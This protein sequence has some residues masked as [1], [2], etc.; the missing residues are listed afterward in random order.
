MAE[1]NKSG[2]IRTAGIDQ[3]MSDIKYKGQILARTNKL[4]SAIQSG[5]VMGF[6]VGLIVAL[7]LVLVPGLMLGG[8]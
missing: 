4:E 7:I 2:A 3:M 1:G 5:G 8:F 6:A